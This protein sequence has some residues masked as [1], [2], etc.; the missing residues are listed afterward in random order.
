[1]DCCKTCLY[2]NPSAWCV[3]CKI[4]ELEKFIKDNQDIY[5][6]NIQDVRDFI[7]RNR[8]ELIKILR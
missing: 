4:F 5:D 7:I 8:E 1:M 6:I 3:D 2:P